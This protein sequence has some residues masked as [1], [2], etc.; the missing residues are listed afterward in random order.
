MTSKD[1]WIEISQM[2]DCKQVCIISNIGAHYRFSIYNQ[3]A[4]TFSCAFHF[5]DKVETDIKTFDYTQLEGYRKTLKNRYLRHFYWQS[6]SVRLV[7]K[8]YKYYILDGEPYCLSSWAILFL[9]R[10]TGK[11]TIAWT[12]GWYGRES[13]AKKWIKKVFYSLHNKLMVYSEYAIHLMQQEG[14][15]SKKMYCIANSMDSD[16]EKE[17]RNSLS[18]TTVY[19]D[20]FGNTFPTI[21]Y[22]GRIQKSKK[23]EMLIDSIHLL[24]EEGFNVNAIVIGKD[25]EQVNLED[26]ARKLGIEKQLWM[27]GPCHDD[28]IL[29]Q[30]FFNAH[31]C[32][33]PGNVGLTAIHSLTFG[34]PVIT[35]NNFSYQGPEF[36]AIQ[37]GITGDFFTQDNTID[38]KE[39]IKNWIFIAPKDRKE[40]RL[41]AYKEIDRKWNI[42]YQVD[43]IK[44]VLHEC[45]DN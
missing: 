16:K 17:L 14:F 43:V 28:H 39:K 38:L 32:V 20:H 26:R 27:Y 12:H 35:H 8:P 11:K 7:F 31:V 15:S 24:K 2:E 5:G 4:H 41:A 6:G 23:L 44:R 34:C 30:L 21:I 10:L 29:S 19:T 37:P 1:S 45:Y 33:S 13:H 25:I 36:E 22:C 18:E 42:H 40:V 9:A 3:M